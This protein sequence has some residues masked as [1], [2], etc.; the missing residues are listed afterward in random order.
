MEGPPEGHFKPVKDFQGFQA[1]FQHPVGILLLSRNLPDDFLREAAFYLVP[2]MFL[3]PEVVELRFTS[4]TYVFSPLMPFSPQIRKI[5]PARIFSMSS[6]SVGG[7]D[8]PV[9]QDMHLIHLE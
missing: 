8:A 1:E 7:H 3:V 5:L 9:D 4:S 2:R 6:G